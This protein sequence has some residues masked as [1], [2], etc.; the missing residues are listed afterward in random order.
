MLVNLSLLG[1]QISLHYILT[2][3]YTFKPHTLLPTDIELQF[4]TSFYTLF[5]SL[6]FKWM[7][8]IWINEAI[9][10]L[11]NHWKTESSGQLF[12]SSVTLIGSTYPQF[13]QGLCL[14]TIDL[15]ASTYSLHY[16]TNIQS[17]TYLT[18]INSLSNF[19]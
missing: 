7:Q 18:S 14:L 17:S 5:N 4:T 11:D 19:N 10:F 16:W 12:R 3:H 15:A 2:K 8:N 13:H 6:N 1:W 9:V